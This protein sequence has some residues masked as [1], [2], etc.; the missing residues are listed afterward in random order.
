MKVLGKPIVFIG[1]MSAGIMQG[2]TI[3]VECFILSNPS[4]VREI[5][6]FKNG[7]LFNGSKRK[8]FNEIIFSFFGNMN[9]KC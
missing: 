9:F 8:I 3:P 6:W 5:K 2:E 4:E 1:P 7:K